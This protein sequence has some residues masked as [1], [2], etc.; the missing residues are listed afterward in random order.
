ML[1]TAETAL[2]PLVAGRLPFEA[3]ERQGLV[4][5]DACGEAG[6]ALRDAWSSAWPTRGYSRFVCS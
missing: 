5:L 2:A 4:H 1:V 3:A 6:D